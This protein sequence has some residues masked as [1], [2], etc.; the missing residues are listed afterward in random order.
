MNSFGGTASETAPPKP[1]QLSMSAY[2]FGAYRATGFLIA[3]TVCR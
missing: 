1:P 2:P 3:G